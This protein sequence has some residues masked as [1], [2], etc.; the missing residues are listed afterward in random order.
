MFSSIS[1]CGKNIL[2]MN[3]SQLQINYVIGIWFLIISGA[4]MSIN[5][6]FQIRK[7][8]AVYPWVSYLSVSS[9]DLRLPTDP[10]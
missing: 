1:K 9:Y 3:L 10:Q 5:Q 4:C 8:T 2:L 7:W 6:K